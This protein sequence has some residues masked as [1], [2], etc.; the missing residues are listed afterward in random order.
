MILVIVYMLLLQDDDLRE[1]I[2]RA[3]EMEDKFG[4]FFD[5]VLVNVDMDKAFDELLTEINRIEVE[6]QWVPMTWTR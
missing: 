3:R 2:E 6:P 5:Y 1:I 4:H